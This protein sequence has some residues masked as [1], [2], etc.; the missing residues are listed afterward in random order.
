M[1]EEPAVAAFDAGKPDSTWNTYQLTLAGLVLPVGLHVLF[2]AL[3]GVCV[4]LLGH[5]WIAAAFFVSALATD[6]FQQ[7]MLRRWL[8]RSPGRDPDRGLLKLGAL[9]AG[10]MV[11]YLVPTTIMTL[12]GGAQELAYFAIQLCSLIILAQAAGSMARRIFWAFATPVVAAIGVVVTLLLPPWAALGCIL[13]LGALLFLLTVISN[14]TFKA[15][16]T[17]HAAFMANVDMVHQLEAARDQ[18]LAEREAANA[19]REEARQANRAKSNF[20]ATMSHEIRTPM[21]GVL[22]MA[23]LLRR[24]E[25]DPAQSER[26][27]V[28]IE[29]GEHLLS[30][31]NDI[32][33]VSKID[34]GRLEITPHAEDLG[35]F[36]TGLVGFWRPRADE[37]GL[38][39]ALHI[40]P[41]APAHVMMDAVR[42]RQVLFNLVG[43]AL[44]FT[45]EGG[46]EVRVEAQVGGRRAPLVHIAVA[47]TGVGIAAH[48]V[49]KLFDRFSQGDETEARRFGGT[50]LGLAIAKQLTELMGGR[51]WVESELGKGSTFHVQI[52]LPLADAPAPAPDKA[53][54]APPAVESGLQVLAVDDNPV[55]LLVLDQLLSSLGHSV[56][57]A[58]GG[59]EALEMLAR[60]PFDIVLMDIHMPGMS[61]VE[62]LKQL[63]IS[64]GPNRAAPVIAL[65]A[66]V[67]SGGRDSFMELGFDEHASKPI[68][69]EALI[70]AMARALAAAGEAPKRGAKAQD[71]APARRRR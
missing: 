15:I 26:L 60:E 22:G 67:T 59:A 41:T 4:L 17:W 63:R 18:A 37:K 40:D 28:L 11:V 8:A 14:T 55:N 21:N 32:L 64:N 33:D 9:C 56:T 46:V 30:I 58:A 12:R 31:L 66:D 36:M 19:A 35:A 51:I 47:D 34:A 1:A 20:L 54:P 16:T 70:E 42:V 29:S 10:R 61:G 2:D 5:P 48:T 39:L 25:I 24:D 68:Q 13:G 7:L 53:L 43:N 50:G 44:K 69:V 62:A 3:A 65:T 27:D 6:A 71:E 23:Q 49:A 52:P 57:K 38:S 45:P